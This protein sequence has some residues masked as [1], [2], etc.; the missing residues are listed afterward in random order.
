[1]FDV[2][3]SRRGILIILAIMVVIALAFVVRG[4]VVGD[5]GYDVDDAVPSGELNS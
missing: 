1:M 5:T 3:R 4:F 2:L